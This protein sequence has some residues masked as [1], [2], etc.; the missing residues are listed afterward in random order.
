MKQIKSI[1]GK[2][3][4]EHEAETQRGIVELAIMNGVSLYEANLRNW[5][6]GGLFL[7]GV[8]LKSACLRG[9][10]LRGAYLEGVDLTDVDLR[11]ANLSGADMRGAILKRADL[12]M[13]HMEGVNLRG[14]KFEDTK[15]FE[16]II[17]KAPLQLM[18][19]IWDVILTGN[20]MKIGCQVHSYEEWSEFNSDQIEAMSVNAQEFWE[21]N[22]EVLLTLMREWKK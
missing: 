12:R 4:F 16:E 6:L 22:K 21:Q 1:H 7:G 13:A 9:T 3:L 14:A 20:T 19:C 10:Y 18:G 5:D 17:N 8:N 2:V 11:N 15:M